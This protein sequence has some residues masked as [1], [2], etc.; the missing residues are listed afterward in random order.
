YGYSHGGLSPQELVTPFFC[1]QLSAAHDSKLP[2]NIANKADL[3]SVAGEIYQIKLSAGEV[4]GN[5]LSLNRKV[6]LVFFKNGAQSNKSDI[7]T[8][9]RNDKICKEYSF[10]GAK[11]IEIQLLDADTKECLDHTKIRRSSD[12]DLGGLL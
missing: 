2:V 5:L 11:E 6:Y 1:W 12:R 8:I 3:E 10:D 9:S 7:L 4:P